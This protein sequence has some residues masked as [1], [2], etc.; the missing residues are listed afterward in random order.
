MQALTSLREIE[1]HFERQPRSGFAVLLE[2]FWQQMRQKYAEE[3]VI[4]F[5]ADSAIFTWTSADCSAAQCCHLQVS[6]MSFS[7]F[8]ISCVYLV[9]FL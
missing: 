2:S 8:G 4:L 6:F 3:K 7:Y 5:D 9:Y 1:E